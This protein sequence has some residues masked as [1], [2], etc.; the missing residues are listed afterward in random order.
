[1]RQRF[2]LH[3]SVRFPVRFPSQTLAGL[4]LCAFC[5]LSL[6][7]CATLVEQQA[8]KL[9]PPK[10]Y[11]PLYMTSNV[12]FSKL[13]AS[14]AAQYQGMN[15]STATFS[16]PEY[17]LPEV[18]P[19]PEHSGVTP[20]GSIGKPSGLEAIGTEPPPDSPL[21]LEFRTVNDRRYPD[22]VELQAIVLDAQGRFV[23]GLAPK[24]GFANYWRGLRDSSLRVSTPIDSFLVA[25]VRENV[26]QPQ[27]VCFV[28]DHS[29]SMGDARARKLQ[30][31]IRKTLDIVKPDDH[32]SVVKFTSKTIVE[33]PLTNDSTAYKQRFKIDGLR[34]YGGGTAIYDAVIAGVEQ[35]SK[36]PPECRRTLILFTDGGDNSSKSNLQ[37]AYRLARARNVRIQTVAYGVTEEAPLEALARYSG[38]KMYRIY[39]TREFPYM[40][41]DIYRSLRNYYRITYKPPHIAGLHTASVRLSPP[42]LGGVSWLARGQYDRSVVTPTDTVGT[43][44][45]VNIEF[46]TGKTTIT[47]ASIPQLEEFARTLRLY[48]AITLEIR[49]H[50]DDRGS[51]ELNQTLS[52]QRA[53]SVAESLIRF[54]VER[55]RLQTRGFGKTQPLAPNDS[56]DNRRK[57][58]RTEFVI[59]GG[60]R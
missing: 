19:P 10:G 5:I 41:A 51:N 54:G 14:L 18:E 45:M 2:F 29:P 34:G 55:R 21:R 15:A 26:K 27:A 46:E 57:N 7:G 59:T 35:L 28:L 53:E 38:G 43:V 39:T 16:M 13:S 47:P 42:E 31:S 36:A 22:E 23:T 40:F 17:T 25:E 1:M 11:K 9:L 58:R 3:S 12:P 60:V 6:A 49:G 32:I 8:E 37:A 52:E 30:E 20:Q 44:T 48:P 33:V 24:Q 50:T 4:I 56:D